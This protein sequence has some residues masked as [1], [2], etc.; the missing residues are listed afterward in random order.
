MP[1]VL[2]SVGRL[3]HETSTALVDNHIPSKVAQVFTGAIASGVTVTEDVLKIVADVSRPDDE[4]EPATDA[5]LPGP[6]SGGSE[7]E[8]LP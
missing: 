4:P 6:T 7:P 3:I 1:T 8:S 2:G 5:E